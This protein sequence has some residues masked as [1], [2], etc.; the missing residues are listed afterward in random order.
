MNKT[1]SAQS[2]VTL[3]IRSGLDIGGGNALVYTMR[4]GVVSVTNKCSWLQLDPTKTM[5]KE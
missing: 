1:R 4:P 2:V 3:Y 5:N